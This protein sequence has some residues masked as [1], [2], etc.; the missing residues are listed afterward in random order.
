[1]DTLYRKGANVINYKMMDVHA[2]GH[3]KKED[4]KLM[5]ALFKTKILRPH[6]RQP[7][8][9]ARERESR[10]LHGM[11]KENVFIVDNGQ[12]M[13]FWKDG[14]VLTNEKVPT[15]Y[16]FVD[17]LGV[18]DVSQVVLR[19]RQVLAEDGMV[20][21]IAQIEKEDWQDRGLPRHHQPRLH[22]HEGASRAHQTDS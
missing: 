21:V 7:L 16:V 1:M 19:D 11:G 3:A 20:I 14:G 4:I 22:L 2:G 6:R 15:D 9:P 10:L 8:P 5:L 18:G 13:E 12:V 17:G